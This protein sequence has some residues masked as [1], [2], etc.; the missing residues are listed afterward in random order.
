MVEELYRRMYPA[1]LARCVAMAGG[2]PAVGEDL[3]QETFLRALQHMGELEDLSGGQRRAWLY[4]TAKNL[5]IDRVRKLSREVELPAGHDP[6]FA[7]DLTAVAVAQLV[8]RLPEP[9]RGLFTLRYF[10]DWNATELGERF[11]MPPAT[12]RSKLAS[13]RKRIIQWINEDGKKEE[14]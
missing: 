10:Q 3:C 14:I 7:Q 4:K 11:G 1:L 8:G 2:N 13:A 12:V 6:P 5:Y 9:E